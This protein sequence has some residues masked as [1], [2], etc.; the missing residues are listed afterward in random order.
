MPTLKCLSHYF[1]ATSSEML[2]VHYNY[3]SIAK[4]IYVFH[5]SRA[6]TD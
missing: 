3:D 6:I 5:R 4:R 1:E 2:K